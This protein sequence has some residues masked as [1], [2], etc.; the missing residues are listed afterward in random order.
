MT[1]IEKLNEK[2]ERMDRLYLSAKTR[3]EQDSALGY[4]RELV[5][6]RNKLIDESPAV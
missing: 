2:I 5:D 6:Q 4:L 3:S 1:K